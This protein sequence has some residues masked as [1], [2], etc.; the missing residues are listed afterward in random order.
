[1]PLI[2]SQE[3]Y[4]DG[5]AALRRVRWSATRTELLARVIIRAVAIWE[6]ASA[7]CVDAEIE[8]IVCNTEPCLCL[9][10]LLYIYVN[11]MTYKAA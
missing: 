7:G 2:S 6:S 3:G 5:K 4:I 11:T 1:M 8:L 9:L 10:K